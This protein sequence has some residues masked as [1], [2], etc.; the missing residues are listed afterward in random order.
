M[1]WKQDADKVDVGTEI[2]VDNATIKSVSANTI[3]IYGKFI[4]NAAGY[5]EFKVAV[6]LG[7]VYLS[8]GKQPKKYAAMVDFMSKFAKEQT[9]KG[10]QGRILSEQDKLEN[11]NKDK[12]GFQQDIVDYNEEI[13]E[14][15]QKILDAKS[16]IERTKRLITGK[17]T[18]ILKQET[19]MQK[20][21]AI[22]VN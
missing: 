8:K 14:L 16:N 12:K 17:D 5:I 10:L 13:A 4:I 22:T 2:F 19:E 18:E 15:E 3:D 1:M 7:G 9:T 20:L 6:N 11:L 21:R